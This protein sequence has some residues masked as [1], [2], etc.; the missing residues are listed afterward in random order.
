MNGLGFVFI[1]GVIVGYALSMISF[2]DD[3]GDWW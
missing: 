2:E 3:D 1:M